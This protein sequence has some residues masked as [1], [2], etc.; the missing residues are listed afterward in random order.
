[1]ARIEMY[2]EVA[3]SLIGCNSKLSIRSGDW[4]LPSQ[5]FD[6]ELCAAEFSELVHSIDKVGIVD[7]IAVR[8]IEPFDPVKGLRF[9]VIAGFRR[10][11][12][13]KLL[14]ERD[15]K[16]PKIPCL[17]YFATDAEA[18]MM[19]VLHSVNHA[20]LYTADL[21]LAMREISDGIDPPI[22]DMALAKMLGTSPAYAAT[23]LYVAR[24]ATPEVFKGWQHDP[25]PLLLTTMRNIA[26]MDPDVQKTAYLE[27]FNRLR[28]DDAEAV[29]DIARGLAEDIMEHITETNVGIDALRKLVSKQDAESQPDHDPPE[30]FSRR[31]NRRAPSEAIQQLRDKLSASIK[32][33]LVYMETGEAEAGITIFVSQHESLT[34]SELQ[35]RSFKA[36][37][38]IHWNESGGVTTWELTPAGHEWYRGQEFKDD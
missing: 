28:Q 14:M 20:R 5:R 7:P 35:F 21:A 2:T 9:E 19:Q 37:G 30:E 16:E 11:A 34:L 12:A 15:A 10:Y 17:V 4:T 26:G 33:P 6:D 25:D 38:L 8:E 27:E 18:R 1:M 31:Y 36:E 22:S 32:Q 3:L 29:R 13:A 24:N 23:M